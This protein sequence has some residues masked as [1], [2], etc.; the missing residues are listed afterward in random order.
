[1]QVL[2]TNSDLVV[3]QSEDEIVVRSRKAPEAGS[4]H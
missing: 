4:F 3:E 1:M 2:K